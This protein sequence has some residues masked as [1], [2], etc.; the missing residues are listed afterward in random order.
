MSNVRVTFEM[1]VPVQ[2]T[3]AEIEEWIRFKLGFWSIDNSNPLVDKSL[4]ADL[5]TIKI[6]EIED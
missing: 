3:D 2:A 6:E 4:S 5:S 1:E